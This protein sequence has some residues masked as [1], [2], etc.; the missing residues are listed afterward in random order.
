MNPRYELPYEDDKTWRARR[1]EGRDVLGGVAVV[2]AV[3]LVLLLEA[4]G[5]VHLPLTDARHAVAA[6]PPAAVSITETC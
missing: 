4:V 3:A 1:V 2:G 6:G 5:V